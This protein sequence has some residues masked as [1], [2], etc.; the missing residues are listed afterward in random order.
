M[1]RKAVP[2][3]SHGASAKVYFLHWLLQDLCYDSRHETA[4][5]GAFIFVQRWCRNNQRQK[6]NTNP[7][8]EFVL[9]PN[10]GGGGIR[11]E[12]S[13]GIAKAACRLSVTLFR[14]PD[15][16]AMCVAKQYGVIKRKRHPLVSFF[17]LW[18]QASHTLA[19][20][21]GFEPPWACTQTVF[22][23]ASLWPL[24]YASVC[25]SYIWL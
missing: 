24:R 3:E 12:R 23:T 15:S 9:F 19:E 16:K 8:S 21:E 11:K 2:C 17:L 6:N 5:F 18:L 10:G 20:A 13:D 22:K 25:I 4:K 1:P 14:C 7:F